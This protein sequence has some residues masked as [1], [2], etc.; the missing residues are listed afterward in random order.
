MGGDT[1]RGARFINHQPTKA[2]EN[3]NGISQSGYREIT[4]RKQPHSPFGM[5]LCSVNNH[6]YVARVEMYTPEF[7]LSPA[8]RA[9]LHFGDRIDVINTKAVNGSSDLQSIYRTLK[10]A[11]SVTLEIDERP[12]ARKICTIRGGE[13][14]GVEFADGKVVSVMPEFPADEAGIKVGDVVAQINNYCTLGMPD[15][16]IFNTMARE[17][18]NA[19]HS[20]SCEVT[21]VCMKP[22][23]AEELILGCELIMSSLNMK[24]VP[25]YVFADQSL[26]LDSHLEEEQ[27]E[28]V[29]V[30]GHAGPRASRG[31][32]VPSQPTRSQSI[33][34]AHSLA[35]NKKQKQQPP[36]LSLNERESV[37][38]PSSSMTTP[39]PTCAET[40]A[41]TLPNTPIPRVNVQTSPTPRIS[42]SAQIG[43]YFQ[44]LVSPG[45]FHRRHS[46]NAR[47]SVD[48]ALHAQRSP[49]TPSHAHRLPRMSMSML[50]RSRSNP[51]SPPSSIPSTPT[52]MTPQ[53]SRQNSAHTVNQ[54][55]QRS[56]GSL[57]EN[58]NGDALEPIPSNREL[59]CPKSASS[60]SDMSGESGP[61]ND[62]NSA[63][64]RN[65]KKKKQ[66]QAKLTISDR[67][68][69]G[70]RNSRRGGGECA[71]S[72]SSASSSARPSVEGESV[73]SMAASSD[74]VVRNKQPR[75][76]LLS[77]FF[78]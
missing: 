18:S 72:S 27:I 15:Q 37:A 71:N 65:T 74:S 16:L 63:T 56:L 17:Q 58:E 14:F 57:G 39:T 75:R 12:A 70:M 67:I 59:P 32:H 69:N 35:G 73:P 22:M 29:Y 9:G 60:E 40:Q 54:A 44:S 11:N 48:D 19:A 3:N 8:Y 25:A 26:A 36:R 20:A 28:R 64:Q 31:V 62:V 6:L 5:M 76:S 13:S 45:R 55:S 38:S 21:L 7:L 77:A 33:T 43:G 49:H 46:N 24:L 66:V 34:P 50:T 1:N 23:F 61:E 47:H 78:D 42:L 4:V 41:L 30:K 52:N 68:L 53:I 2:S 10:G 51:A